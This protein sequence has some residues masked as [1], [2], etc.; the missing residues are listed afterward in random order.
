LSKKF[1]RNNI[2]LGCFIVS[3]L[4]FYTVVARRDRY[5]RDVV[6]GGLAVSGFGWYRLINWL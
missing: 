4:L 6:G 1:T 5:L 3:R 2:G